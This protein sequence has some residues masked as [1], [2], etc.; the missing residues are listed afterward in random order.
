[1]RGHALF[2]PVIAAL[3]GLMFATAVAAAPPPVVRLTTNAG[4]IDIELDQT[5]APRTVENFLAYVRAGFYNGTIFHRVIPGFMIQGGGFTPGMQEKP[6][7]APIA[8]EA[9][10]GLKNIAGT[11]A[12]ART[13]DPHSASAQFF[14][15][16][17]D[18][19]ALDHRGKNPRD[20][21][22]AV[23]GRVVRGMD[24]VKKIE[25]VPTT[26]KGGH[27]DVP[28]EDVLIKHAQVLKPA[29][30]AQKP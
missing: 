26:Y 11:I 27:A 16:T 25:A 13:P 29:A 9:G 4:V 5:R 10:N 3:F 18:N 19:P 2:P 23:F 8:N 6:T 30:K 7:R 24:V 21:G 14:I 17:V 28:L 22:Y 15:N 12:M 1:M 20:W